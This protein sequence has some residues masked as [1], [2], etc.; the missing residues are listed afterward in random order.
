MYGLIVSFFILIINWQFA[1]LVISFII[2][3]L[4]INN[5]LGNELR[6][7]SI[8]ELVELITRENYLQV[9]SNKGSIN[10]KELKTVI[11][12]WFSD[13]LDMEKT[14]LTNARFV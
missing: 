9:R 2:I 5:K 12:D 14:E 7:K 11:L 3:C 6:V 1:L 13:N 4:T 8:K 10:R